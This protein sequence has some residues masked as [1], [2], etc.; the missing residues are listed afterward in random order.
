M[1]ASYIRITN[2]REVL[3]K[4]VPSSTKANFGYGNSEDWFPSGTTSVSHTFDNNRYHIPGLEQ[5][6]FQFSGNQ[7]FT[8]TVN[9]DWYPEERAPNGNTVHLALRGIDLRNANRIREMTMW[10]DGI[11]LFMRGGNVSV[12]GSGMFQILWRSNYNNDINNDIFG[13]PMAMP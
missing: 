4:G 8:G 11:S 6:P 12:N 9:L 7:R 3:K 5:F 1:N 10:H 2:E 13:E